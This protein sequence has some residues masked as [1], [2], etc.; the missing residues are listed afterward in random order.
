MAFGTARRASAHDATRYNG[1]RGE[2]E[3]LRMPQDR[4]GL[5]LTAGS[6]EAVEALN[7]ALFDFLEARL[8]LGDRIKT[9]LAA[10][11]DCVM[12]LC[13]RGYFLMQLSSVATAGKVGEVLAQAKERA[14]DATA[15]EQKHVA[16]LESWL[17]GRITRTRRLWE[18]ILAEHPRDLLALRLHHFASFWQG[19]REALRDAP[20][21]VLGQSDESMPGYGF[22][23]GMFAFGLEENGDYGR[24]EEVSREAVARNPDDLWALHSLAHI[25]EMQCR[26]KE[27]ASLLER[28]FGTWSDRNPFKDHV[29][30]HR[31]LFLLELGEVESMMEVYDREVR[32]KEGGFYLDVQNAAS[33][34]QRMELAGIDTQGR[35]EELADLAESRLDDHVLPFTDAHFMLALVG[36]GRLEAAHRYIE[37]LQAFA[38]SS[39]SEAAQVTG[40]LTL[41]L[42]QALLAYGEGRYGEAADGLYALRHELGPLGGSHAQQDVFQQLLI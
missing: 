15:R 37:S 6:P 25:L 27:G 28:P 9:A 17:A 26:H 29:W 33:L 18:E 24:A 14:G 42:A 2:R 34:L 7:A 22:V 11:P 1:R 12:A 3:D 31:A 36:G 23:Q 32:V 21:A 5:E 8:S 19:D 20:A 16:A 4:L 39:D 38:A 30:W 13:F 35:W 40:R 41:P 10:D